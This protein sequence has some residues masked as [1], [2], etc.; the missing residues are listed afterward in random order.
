M[1]KTAIQN[2]KVLVNDDI[3]DKQLAS[4]I[5]EILYD[6]GISWYRLLSTII[7]YK[8]SEE[9]K[10]TLVGW[11]DAI[12]SEMFTCDLLS[13]EL[14]KKHLPIMKVIKLC[15]KHWNIPETNIARIKA[16]LVYKK[17]GVQRNSFSTPHIDNISPHLVLL[18]YASDSDGD[19]IV[20]NKRIGQETNGMNILER[21]SPKKG[22]CVLFDGSLYH[23][24]GYPSEYDIRSTIN[25]N[26][27]FRF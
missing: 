20:W 4:Q 3:V 25:F 22:R 13:N 24:A 10:G 5:D 9:I 26:L 12:E 15:S 11:P 17:E 21:I 16:N 27:L 19:T 2:N 8:N 6:R 23:S 18:Y 14:F 1:W 7:G